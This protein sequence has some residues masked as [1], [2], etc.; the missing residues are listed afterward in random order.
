MKKAQHYNGEEIT[1][2]WVYWN[3]NPLNKRTG[4]CVIRAISKATGKPW[5][6]LL[7][8]MT[9]WLIP[10]GEVFDEKAGFGPYLEE[11]LH[12]Q[13]MR[14]PKH[15]DGTSYP[16]WEFLNGA[17]RNFHI[18]VQVRNHLTY[19]FN[20]QFYDIW[21]C[22]NKCVYNFWLKPSKSFYGE[23]RSQTNPQATRS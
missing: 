9:E 21:D 15:A 18:I 17:Q 22:T 14:M 4:D 19:V 6:D 8:E 20:G 3:P 13:K 16:L 10:R 11:V 5:A 7:R 23:R 1:P 12:F 2:L